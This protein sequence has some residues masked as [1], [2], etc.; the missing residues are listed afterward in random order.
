MKQPTQTALIMYV[1]YEN[2]SDYPGKFVVRK[3]TGE[4]P[5]INPTI[6][7]HSLEAAR[8]VIPK[9]KVM[10]LPSVTD[11]PVIIENWL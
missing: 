8:N 5:D 10:L 2:P 11:D 7:A 4:T 3:F 6:V 9:D 1:V